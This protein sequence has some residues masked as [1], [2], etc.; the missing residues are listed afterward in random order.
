MGRH[1]KLEEAR[2]DDLLAQGIVPCSRCKEEKPTEEFGRDARRKRGIT[3]TCK[4]C[5]N[6]LSL[7]NIARCKDRDLVDWSKRQKVYQKRHRDKAKKVDPA[8]TAKRN[9]T[10]QLKTKYGITAHERDVLL[11]EQDG[12]C[13][14]CMVPITGDQACVDHDHSCCPT[15]MTCGQCIRGILCHQCN[16]GIGLLGDTHEAIKQTEIYLRKAA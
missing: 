14:S 8:G 9:Q 3:S 12:R 13:A 5:T 2:R 15:R 16:K 4:S 6:R 1:T 10:N 7:E 11:A